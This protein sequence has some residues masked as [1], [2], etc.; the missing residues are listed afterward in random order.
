MALTSLL[1][2]ADSKARQVLTRVLQDLGIQVEPCP[3]AG[4]AASRL[5]GA[6]FDAV[7]LDCA[8]EAAALDV[9]GKVRSDPSHRAALLVALVESENNVRQIF[10]QGANFLLYKPIS[11][12]RASSSLRAARGLMRREKRRARRVRVHGQA[13]IAYSNREDVSAT[14]LNVSEEGI[15][16]Q[17]EGKLP[18][19]C[20]VY[21]EFMLPGNAATVRLSGEV[22]WQDAAGRVGIRFADVPKTSRRILMDWLSANTSL[23]A[24]PQ[25]TQEIRTETRL[26]PN[27]AG[28]FGLLTVSASDRRIKSRRACH[29]GAEVYA[30]G[31]SVPY[32]CNLSDISIGGCYVESPQPFPVGTMVDIKVRTEAFRVEVR[33]SVQSSH[34]GFGMGVEFTLRT[35]E[36]KRQVQQLIA[37]QPEEE[38][39]AVKE[40]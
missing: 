18:P 31:S 23:E 3:D 14:L 17:A 29:L 37:C 33:G 39:L 27:S 9:I 11:A 12:E 8:D 35:A 26:D 34:P 15:A 20:K 28:G 38:G 1:V 2:C 36:Q 40:D 13:A 6:H 4:S 24:E 19:K 30:V 10:A 22:S 5:Q 16:I 21:F 32:R 7:V 25:A